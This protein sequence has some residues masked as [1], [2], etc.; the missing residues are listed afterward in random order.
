MSKW[1]SVVDSKTGKLVSI[2]KNVAAEIDAIEEQ[3]HF[4]KITK[5]V[6]KKL[7]ADLKKILPGKK[8]VAHKVEDKK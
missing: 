7:I 6:C 1:A 2:P 5:E 3:Y 8:E 4:G